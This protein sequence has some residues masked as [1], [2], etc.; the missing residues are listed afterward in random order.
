MS[1]LALD[2]PRHTRMRALVSKGFT[3]RRVRDLADGIR[4]LA[5]RHLAGALRQDTFDFVGDFAGR[6]PCAGQ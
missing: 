3:P 5:Q 6:P 1:F 4:A 2:P